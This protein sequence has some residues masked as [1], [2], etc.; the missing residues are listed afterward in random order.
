MTGVGAAVGFQL[1][2]CSEAGAAG[3][4][5]FETGAGFIGSAGAEVV[6]AGAQGEGGL[7]ELLPL[8]EL[9]MAVNLV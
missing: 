4:A 5:G 9:S 6:P 7:A 1:A 2:G 8:F 3:I